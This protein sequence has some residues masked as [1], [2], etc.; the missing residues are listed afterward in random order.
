V[1]V[2]ILGSSGGGGF[3]QWNCNCRNCRAARARA[4]GFA[5]RTQ[6]SLAVS[7]DGTDWLLLNASPD[8]RQQIAAL[9]R[10]APRIEAGPRS[11][12]IKAVALTNGDV[13]HVAGLL[14]LRERHPFDLY[15]SARVLAALRANPIFDVL[16]PDLVS[17]R[18][19][20]PGVSTRVAGGGVSL[21]LE[22]EAFEAPGKVALYLEELD[23]PNFGTREGD[24]LGLR[25]VE[26]ATGKAFVYLPACAR[27]DACVS[28][29]LRD[30]DLVF[31]DGTLWRDDEMLAQGL[32]PKT[33]S[34]MGHMNMSGPDGSIAAFA[35]LCVK[36]K[37]FIHINN[38]NPVLDP[39]SPERAAAHAAGWTIGEDGME[40]EL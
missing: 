36:Q 39:S 22:V 4:P 21:G 37:V 20:T 38:S 24:T 16:A 9:P 26:S 28:E 23:A 5:S 27:L 14:T 29:R 13:D 12:P 17:R 30:A 32:M 34:R 1:I 10:L 25:I 19:L 11:S 31:F 3:P 35:P 15:A 33:G 2:S 8:L 40:F 18:E 6:S 7:A